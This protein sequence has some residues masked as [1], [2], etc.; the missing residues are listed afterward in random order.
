MSKEIRLKVIKR[1]GRSV[2]FNSDKIKIAIKSAS[3][4]KDIS[5]KERLSEEQIEKVVAF[6]E[7]KLKNK[8]SIEVDEIQD[9]VEDGLMNK[10]FY[11]VAK[12]YIKYREERTKLRNKKSEMIQRISEK[13]AASNVQN[14]N[15]NLDEFSF[16]GRKGEAEAELSRQMALDYYI[17]PKAVKNHLNNRV[18]IHDL[19]SYVIGCHNCLSCPI[20]ELLEK[21]FNTRQVFIRPAN[22]ISTAMQLV[23]V[24]FQIQSLS[25]FG[26]ISATHIDTSMVPYVRKSF[27]KHFKDGLKYVE[28]LSD[29]EIEDF[30]QE[31]TSGK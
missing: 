9:L 29:K 16:G 28:G 21:G 26:G 8:D 19:D 17:S 15:A 30:V 12:S 2:D 1:D 4:S 22:S 31:L 24:L 7:S 14:Q 20:D 27:F 18:Y 13:L 23:A 10:N 6:V 11:A 5:D 3:K 25:Q